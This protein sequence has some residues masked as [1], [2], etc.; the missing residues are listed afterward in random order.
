MG[1]PPSQSTKANHKSRQIPIKSSKVPELFVSNDNSPTFKK[2]KL[3]KKEAK[4]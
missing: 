3:K 1:S 2:D 4:V